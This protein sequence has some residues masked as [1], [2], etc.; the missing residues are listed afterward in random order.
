MMVKSLTVMAEVYYIHANGVIYEADDQDT[1]AMV[2]WHQDFKYSG[3]IVICE[4]VEYNDHTWTVTAIG[5]WAFKNSDIT[6]VIIPKTIKVID[7]YAFY[8]CTKLNS[9]TFSEGLMTIGSHA[10]DQ[11]KALTSISFPNTVK[12]IEDYAF[13]YCTELRTVTLPASLTKMHLVSFYFS[14]KLD[15]V[16]SYI[17]NPSEVYTDFNVYYNTAKLIVPYSYKTL[18]QNA[19]YWRRFTNIEEMPPEP[20][21]ATGLS[22]SQTSMTMERGSTEQLAA[23]VMPEDA[24]DKSVTWS[25]SN[26][27]I[28]TVKADG[29]VTALSIGTAT[30]TCTSV[31][32]PGLTAECTVTVV[33]VA[34]LSIDNSY[35]QLPES[36]T[37][38]MTV[39]VTPEKAAAKG[40]TWSSSDNSVAT[41]SADGL[42][43]AISTGSARIRCSSNADPSVKDS[44]YMNVTSAWMYITPTTLTLY[45]GD[46]ATI[47][48][49]IRPEETVGQQ[50]VTWESSNPDVAIVDN[51]GVLHALSKG[52]AT[53]T[54]RWKWNTNLSMKCTVTVK[55]GF[56]QPV[57][58]PLPATVEGEYF[59]DGDP[60]FGKAA[61]IDG[62]EWGSKEYEMDLGNVKAGAHIL[63]VRCKDE[64]GRWSPTISR[65]LYVCRYFDVASIFC[66]FDDNAL[67][68]MVPPYAH[69]GND[70]MFEIPVSELPIGLHYLHVRVMDSKGRW[71]D[72]ST[73]PFS[74][75]ETGTGIN[76]VRR[77]FAF[78]IDITNTRCTITADKESSHNDCQIDVYDIDGSKIATGVLPAAKQ[79]ITLPVNVHHR[80]IAVVRIQDLKDGR[81]LSRRIV[82]D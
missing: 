26:T 60:G 35:F 23:T 74:I 50:A 57:A 69:K 38:Q 1:T 42:V 13:A 75:I 16:T 33:P 58:E 3:D 54:C 47:T 21:D 7:K 49:T 34:E 55:K 8:N 39:T 19:D 56:V 17:R 20:G 67:G 80:T 51:D 79:M 45:E 37:K 72:L 82:I 4:Q 24:R 40:V 62:M 22:I 70:V 64:Y 65:P 78:D 44:V 9:V 12:I 43:T 48:H 52:T 66:Y 59:I 29:T 18:Y 27:K 30:I 36:G 11:C 53:I 2:T 73:E 63:Y 46:N 41:V 61:P 71:S 10:F 81:I 32:N 5:E 68:V 15:A 31:S 76:E 6:S 28:A 77:N 14:T 25:S